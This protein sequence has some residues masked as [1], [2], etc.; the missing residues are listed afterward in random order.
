M[1]FDKF[2]KLVET[3]FPEYYKIAEDAKLFIFDV[4][5]HQD[6]PKSLPTW[7]DSDLFSLPFPVTA[8][9]DKASLLLLVGE[10]LGLGRKRRVIELIS[11]KTDLSNFADDEN[12][13][14]AAAMAFQ[15]EEVILL[16]ESIVE[17]FNM[18]DTSITGRVTLEKV[19][20]IQGSEIDRLDLKTTPEHERHRLWTSAS[21][22][23]A[24]CMQELIELAHPKYF[25][26]E[27]RPV[28]E[29]KK[30]KLIRTQ[31][32]PI[33]TLVTA[34]EFRKRTQMAEPTGRKIG[35]HERRAHPR[36]YS[37]EGGFY[38][39]DKVITIAANWIGPHEKTIKNKVYRV[40]L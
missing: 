19:I 31:D 32:R 35:G 34:K 12:K 7:F 21:Q 13:K 30:K 14:K 22:N 8:V 27:T 9:E 38:K 40:L 18:V 6:L 25:I 29:P 33:Y 24:A 23:I 10:G 36:R 20:Y 1:L 2:L 17:D 11:S 37:T 28:K 39:T 15:G 3:H 16:T 26:M 4:V 5:P